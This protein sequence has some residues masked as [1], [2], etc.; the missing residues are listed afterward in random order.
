MP[1]GDRGG[2]HQHSS[3]MARP[4]L[5]QTRLTSMP[6]SNLEMKARALALCDI[7]EKNPSRPW[8][9]KKGLMAFLKSL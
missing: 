9:E 7:A 6:R 5:D 2:G 4:R 8:K 1:L 3:C